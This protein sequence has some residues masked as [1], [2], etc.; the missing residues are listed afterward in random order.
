MSTPSR[1]AP[2][3]TDAEKLRIIK[4]YGHAHFHQPADLLG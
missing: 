3:C 1:P 4:Q 2:D